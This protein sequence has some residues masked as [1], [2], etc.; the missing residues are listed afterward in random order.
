VAASGVDRWIAEQLEPASID[1]HEMEAKLENLKSLHMSS[2]ELHAMYP[3]ANKKAQAEAAAQGA[4]MAPAMDEQKPKE[5]E[6]ELAAH[7]I[8]RAVE[9]KRQLAEVLLDFWFNHF[10]VYG[11]KGQDKWLVISY[12]RDAIRPHI[13]GHFRELLE[14]TAKHPAM[15]FY[16]DNWLSVAAEPAPAAPPATGS[17]KRSSG[18]NENYAR[19]LLELHTLGVDG[20][21]SQDDVRETARAFTGWSISHPNEEAEFAFHAKKH[22]RNPKTVLGHIID[23]GGIG[24]GERVLDLVA[25]HPSTARFIATKLCRKFVS[26]DP[27]PSLVTRIASVFSETH[28]DLAAVYEAIFVSPEFWSDA[29]Y[30]SKIKTPLELSASAMRA[31]GATVSSDIELQPQLTRMGEPLYRAL[32]PTGYKEAADAWV[33]SGALVARINFGLALASGRLAG[34]SFEADK[35]AGGSPPSDAGALVDK[36]SA[37]IMHRPLLAS[38]RDTIVNGIASTQQQLGYQEP[39]SE[40]I[41]RAIGLILGSPEFQKQ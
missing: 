16:L 21:Y 19:E 40:E 18:L 13:F 23:A 29:S 39:M 20:G 26:D 31:L 24:D 15:L 3:K 27:P 4:S 9:S 36:L 35:L 1:D 6:K 25:E 38:T 14:A 37:A 41:P 10:N 11:D 5:I 30:E 2:T 33:N 17:G 32:P 12:E 34:V 8:V 22:D 28:G 7:R